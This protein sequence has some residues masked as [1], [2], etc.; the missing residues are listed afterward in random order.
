MKLQDA[1]QEFL[2]RLNEHC[3]EL[4]PEEVLE[5]QIED[6]LFMIVAQSSDQVIT[7][8]LINPENMPDVVNRLEFLASH[9]REYI[10]KEKTLPPAMS[11]N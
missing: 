6:P 11:L 1:L 10:D 2:K 9:L 4:S 5:L 8:M 7:T 3:S